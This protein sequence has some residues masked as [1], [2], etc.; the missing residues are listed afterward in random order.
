MALCAG[1][2]VAAAALVALLVP[3]TL[4]DFNDWRESLRIGDKSAAELYETN[5]EIDGVE[6]AFVLGI[7]ALATFLLRPKPVSPL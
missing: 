1:V 4:R 5:L 3:G 2:L 6:I 7:A